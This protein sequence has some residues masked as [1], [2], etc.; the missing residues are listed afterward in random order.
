MRILSIVALAALLA[1]LPALAQ[2]G[3][4]ERSPDGIG[5]I[6]MGREIAQVMGHLGAGWLERPQRVDEER[7]DI[8]VAGMQLKPADV[9]ADIGAGTGYFSIRI[10]KAIP[11]GK[12]LA[13]DIQPE[14][15]ALLQAAMAKQGVTNIESI[16]ST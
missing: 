14:M 4:T 10:A 9:V 16:L 15:V 5:T 8:V 12:V 3:K 13:V 2:Y 7:P 11:T 1:A 6:Y